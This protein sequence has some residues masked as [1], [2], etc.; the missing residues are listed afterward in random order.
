VVGREGVNDLIR[1]IGNHAPGL[2][3]HLIGHS[4][5]GRVVTAAADASALKVSGMTLLQAAFSHYSFAHNYEPGSDGLFR[6]VVTDRKVTGPILIT[7]SN[8]D[9]AV[10]KAYAIASAIAGQIAQALGDENDRYGGLGRNGARLTPEAVDG[11][12]QPVGSSYQFTG[13][14]IFNLTADDIILEHSDICKPEV[15]YAL[16]SA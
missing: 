3:I 6:K 5:G 12:L 14:K 8:R 1:E 16:L 4:F 2:R 11:N 15:A 13:G 7:H 10:G 9:T